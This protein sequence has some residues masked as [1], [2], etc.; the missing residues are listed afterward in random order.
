[1]TESL[2]VKARRIGDDVTAVWDQIR[3]KGGMIPH[4]INT[5]NLADVLNQIVG[6][7]KWNA[8]GVFFYTP[9]GFYDFYTTHEVNRWTELP[10]APAGTSWAISLADLKAWLEN[11]TYMLVGNDAVFPFDSSF[12][13][14]VDNPNYLTVTLMISVEGAEDDVKILWGDGTISPVTSLTATKYSHTYA[15]TGTYDLAIEVNGNSRVTIHTH[16]NNSQQ[17]QDSNY[18]SNMFGQAGSSSDVGRKWFM[19]MT[20]AIIGPKTGFGGTSFSPG[21]SGP[22]NMPPLTNLTSVFYSYDPE[23][24][25]QLTGSPITNY[26]MPNTA[27]SFYSQDP[28]YSSADYSGGFIGCTNLTSVTMSPYFHVIPKLCFMG[29]K[30]TSLDFSNIRR[31]EM[32]AF[33]RVGLVGEVDLSNVT[34][35]M[36]NTFKVLSDNNTTTKIILNDE[37]AFDVNNHKNNRYANSILNGMFMNLTNLEEINIPTSWTLIPGGFIFNSDVDVSS[38]TFPHGLEYIARSALETNRYYS[39]ATVI[40]N[41]PDSLIGLGGTGLYTYH[42]DDPVDDLASV[43]WPTSFAEI[44]GA[45]FR[46]RKIKNLSLPAT[47]SIANSAFYGMHLEDNTFTIPSTWTF[48]NGTPQYAFY[49]AYIKKLI[50]GNSLFLQNRFFSYTYIDEIEFEAGLNPTNLNGAFNNIVGGASGHSS[51]ITVPASVTTLNA[52]EFGPGILHVTFEGQVPALTTANCLAKMSN[53]TRV[54]DM[55]NCATVPTLNVAALGTNYTDYLEFIVP[56]AL[57]ASWIADTNWADAITNKHINVVR[58]SEA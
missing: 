30:L 5:E 14:V 56:D 54:Y 58:A 31:I 7:D 13:L 39:L 38:L 17:P 52:N 37:V 29:T 46:N 10:A 22:G 53:Y 19:Y 32:R 8:K 21:V 34:E 2:E 3:A 51:K 44:G 57:Y 48:Y 36:D 50:I 20:S 12:H 27:T 4:H 26:I 16:Y 23:E 15:T 55:S 43:T 35:I 28:N 41:L 47:L 24:I 9:D 1:M 49:E 11:H 45:P 40:S 6:I 25:V 18:A 33:E 42:Q